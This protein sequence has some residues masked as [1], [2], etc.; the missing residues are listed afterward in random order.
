MEFA[1]SATFGQ[2][3]LQSYSFLADRSAKVD[4]IVNI[5]VCNRFD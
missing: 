3:E 5:F 1:P 4:F 2:G